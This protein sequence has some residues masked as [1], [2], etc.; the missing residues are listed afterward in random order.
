M[1]VTILAGSAAPPD[2]DR[3]AI[4][5]PDP[6]AF[7]MIKKSEVAKI[8]DVSTKHINRAVKD[9]FIPPPVTVGKR[10]KRWIL[11][12]LIEYLRKNSSKNKNS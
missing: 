10:S 3:I 7:R 9:G 1:S 11:S 2:Q 12:D 8:M 5:A 6:D 4:S